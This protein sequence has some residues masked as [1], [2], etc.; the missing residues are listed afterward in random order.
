VIA[1]NVKFFFFF[2]VVSFVLYFS[3]R[4][5][6]LSCWFPRGGVGS[7]VRWVVSCS[8]SRFAGLPL[9]FFKILCSVS[10]VLF[11]S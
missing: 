5:G 4:L 3:K 8:M 7:W 6:F 9:F 10:F 1:A 11:S 2:G